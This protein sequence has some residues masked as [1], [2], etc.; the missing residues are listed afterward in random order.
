MGAYSVPLVEIGLIV[1]PNTGLGEGGGTYV[2][3]AF[4]VPTS[5]EGKGSE[6]IELVEM[7]FS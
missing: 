6:S 2:P 1:Q 4:L 5:L 7:N 3:S